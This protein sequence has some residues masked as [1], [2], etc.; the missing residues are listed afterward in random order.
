M[1]TRE[2]IARIIF[3]KLNMDPDWD[4]GYETK[5]QADACNDDDLSQQECLELADAILEAL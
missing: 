5:A 2:K 1:S 3:A 4:D